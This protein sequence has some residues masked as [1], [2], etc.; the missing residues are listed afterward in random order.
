M[1]NRIIRTAIIGCGGI[2]Q[3]HAQNLAQLADRFE[4]VAF[5]DADA[6]R[7]GKFAADYGSSKATVYTAPAALLDA[8][9]L[10]AVFICL[11]PF[12]HTDEVARAAARGVHVF[13]EKPIALDSEQ[14]WQMVAAAEA[15]GITTQVGFMFR[16]GGAIGRLKQMMASGEA[17]PAGL[18]ST[19]YFCNAL[20]APWWRQR[21]KSGGQLVEQVIHMVDLM[22]YLMGEA[23]AVYSVQRNLYHQAVADYTVEDVSG[24]VI[25]FASGGIGVI[26]AS[27]NAIPGKWINDY[28]VVTAH[29]T[30][31]FTD[32]NHATFYHTAGGTVRSEEV[33]SEEDVY[34]LEVLDFYEA[35][36][37]GR[38]A[39]VPLRE[40]AR[41]LD[42]ALAARASSDAGTVVQLPQAADLGL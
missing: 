42:L 36:V 13:I 11:P 2:A 15:A 8:E 35:V 39:R 10:D 22:R 30:A 6:E 7:A 27:N 37:D 32:A 28:K 4:L 20:H 23:A 3:R 31:E 40:G 29:V 25:S 41:S 24:T 34:K 33:T 38:Q 1:T 5:A 12:A 18:M 14:A 19:R 17:G 16:F 21:D 9:P 26:Y